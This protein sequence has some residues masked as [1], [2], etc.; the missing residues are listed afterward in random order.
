LVGRNLVI[1]GVIIAAVGLAVM[2]GVPLGRLPGD[3]I[4]RRGQSTVYLPIVTCLVISVVL[5]LIM[6]IFRR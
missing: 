1:L 3:I 2:A 4:W 5:S 6:T